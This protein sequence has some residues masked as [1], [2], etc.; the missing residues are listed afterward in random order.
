[1]QKKLLTSAL[2]LLFAV[3][4]SAQSIGLEDLFV[5]GTFRQKSV[6]GLASMNDGLNYTKLE[7][8]GKEIVKYS[9]K[10][11]QKIAT[12]RDMTFLLK[13]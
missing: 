1:M 11:G 13:K 12:K 2:L 10:T 3:S 8:V 9:Y 7:Y 6:Y 5:K 4:V